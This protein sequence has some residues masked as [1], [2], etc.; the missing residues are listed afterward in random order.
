MDSETPVIDAMEEPTKG[1]RVETDGLAELKSPHIPS[2]F[3]AKITATAPEDEDAEIEDEMEEN[4][5]RCEEM[6]SD[7]AT[8]QHSIA[9]SVKMHSNVDLDLLAAAEAIGQSAASHE[10]PA[11]TATLAPSAPR[12]IV[13][14]VRTRRPARSEGLNQIANYG[15]SSDESSIEDAPPAE[16]PELESKRFPP[17]HHPPPHPTPAAPVLT[18]RPWGRPLN[19]PRRPSGGAGD[20]EAHGAK[21]AGEIRSK[22]EI[23]PPPTSAVEPV[24]VQGVVQPLGTVSA[25]VDC[26]VVIQSLRGLPA[27]DEE[28][29]VCLPGGR[30]VG[31]VAEVF[32][33]IYEPL[34]ILRFPR[35]PARP[36]PAPLPPAPPCPCPPS[37]RGGGRRGRAA[38]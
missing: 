13:T 14:A 23:A 30:A 9:D 32:G 7:I 10:A 36:P 29:I 34:Y 11:E 38:R 26:A 18:P 35:S 22:N 1:Q 12:R 27:M 6:D 5:T 33:P 25:V 4:P 15:S 8:A 24:V 17:H 21:I 19:P 16:A 28:S 37:R 31:T 2:H 3:S 20:D